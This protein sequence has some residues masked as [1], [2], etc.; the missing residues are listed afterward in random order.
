[1]TLKLRK[2]IMKNNNYWIVL[3]FLFPFIIEASERISG[4][5]GDIL[6]INNYEP[7]SVNELIL[8]HDQSEYLIIGLPYV[9]QTSIKKI[10][11][12]NIEI[13]YKDFGESRIT[14]ED[15]SK[16]N[17]N[18]KDRKR[19]NAEAVLIR[20][21]VKTYNT[22]L[23]PSF[24]FINP[25]EGIISSRYGKKRFINEQPRSPHLALDIAANLGVE[26]VAPLKGKTILIGNFF[27][28]GNTIIIDHGFGLISSYSH[29]NS[30]NTKEGEM[31]QQGDMIGTVG[32]T[33]RVTG[34]HLHWTVYLNQEKINPENL[35]KDNFLLTLF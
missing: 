10:G 22:K 33:G 26:I 27:Y 24:N 35:L 1:M 3:A 31:V 12:N 15:I 29:L 19:A 25:V 13:R 21:A 14:I 2:L 30:I 16:V 20:N 4:T 8:K 23:S 6:A 9:S 11:V 7:L 32:E 17:L 34:P 28:T 5:S 18:A